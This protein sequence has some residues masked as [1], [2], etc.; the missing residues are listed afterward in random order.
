[1]RRQTAAILIWCVIAPV[2]CFAAEQLCDGVVSKPVVDLSSAHDRIF[3]HPKSPFAVFLFPENALGNHIGIIYYQNMTNPKYGAWSL[4]NR[5][6][7]VEEWA[8][9]VTSFAWADNGFTLYVGTSEVYGTGCVYH[10]DLLQRKAECIFPTANQVLK[11]RS[12]SKGFTTAI[13]A[14]DEQ[15]GVLNIRLTTEAGSN[16]SFFT[17]P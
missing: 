11:Y 2:F 6:W 17:L 3:R 14:V 15:K 5:F 4:D 8:S 9:D 1:M 16:E 10:L 13:L 12:S 7:Q